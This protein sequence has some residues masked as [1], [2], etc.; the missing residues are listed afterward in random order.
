VV[1]AT[2]PEPAG[3]ASARLTTTLQDRDHIRAAE[4]LQAGACSAERRPAQR[5]AQIPKTSQA[6]NNLRGLVILVVLAFHS[7]SAYLGSTAPTAYAFDKAPFLW[8]AFPI[9]DR[10]R[11]FG[12]DLICAWQDVYVM[13]LMF[14]L[15][16]LFT[17]PSLA[18][19]G[20][21]KFLGD[22]FLRLGVPFAFGVT[23]MMPLALYP[24]Y[25]ET[26]ADPSLAAYTRHYLALPFIPNGPMWFLWQLL[27]LTVIAAGI[28]RFAPQWIAALA[29]R[30]AD[31]A[32]RP[33]RYF[34]GLTI[35]AVL[36]YV[37]MAIL[38]TP[39]DWANHGPLSLQ[40]CRP[41]LYAVFY[42]AGLGVGAQNLEGGLLAVDGV[43][44]RHWTRW[45]AG[46]TL[47]FAL[48]IGL[49]ATSM[50]SSGAAPLMLQCATD[51]CFVVASVCGSFAA[52]AACLRFATG[53]SR[54]LNSFAANAFGM[55]VVHYPFVVW[56]QYSLLGVAVF[57]AAKASLVIAGTV[58]L[59][60]LTT[61]AMLSTPIV[62]RL[63]GGERPAMKRP[64]T[65]LRNSTG[66]GRE[67]PGFRKIGRPDIAL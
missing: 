8:S 47:S 67:V 20:T 19:K 15:S 54:L 32:K 30:A 24:A 64:R 52:L 53:Q 41:L 10:Q 40:F 31:A 37:P 26:A 57:A 14:F 3:R 43:V 46:A 34:I 4:A 38:F 11:W 28:H 61:F 66:A 29:R 16:A 12:F 51:I 27:A 9:V 39:F 36:V 60:W 56:L 48:W 5:D 33:L 59:A 63:I 21:R 49:M 50:R 55:Y 35:A 18:R 25:R 6:L 44:A 7:V 13:S 42:F 62:S 22:R 65:P 1:G 58:L 17:A 23:V 45:L 2:T